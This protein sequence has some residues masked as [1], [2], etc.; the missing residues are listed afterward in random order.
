LMIAALSS[1]TRE[2]YLYRVD[3]RLRP[4][5]QKGRLVTGSDAFITYAERRASL[6]EWLAYVKLR[7]V[8]GSLEF[9]RAV[10]TSA[11]KVIHEL[12][13]GTDHDQLRAET[14]RVRDRLEKEKASRRNAGLNIKHGPGGMLDVYF[15]ARYLQLRDSVQ[16]DEA[17]RTT[18]STLERLRDAGALDETDFRALYE[19]YAL[20]RSV[21][22]Q[23]RLIVGR[24]AWLPLP[25]HPAF[26]D[27]ARRLGYDDPTELTRELSENMTRIR[28]AYERIIR[29]EAD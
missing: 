7:A 4:D 2:G 26:R 6:W 27:I 12:A 9:G 14:R 29:T 1:I 15:A 3:L 8:A 24:S 16:D 10:E 19:G 17:D 20:L 21:D 25:Q 13:E 28:G 23:L 18:R 5:G 11:R 22:H